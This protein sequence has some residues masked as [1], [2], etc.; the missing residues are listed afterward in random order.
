MYV[1]FQGDIISLIQIHKAT[2][3]TNKAKVWLKLC[4]QYN[5]FIIICDC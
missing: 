2:S 5:E 1:N 4:V 3:N